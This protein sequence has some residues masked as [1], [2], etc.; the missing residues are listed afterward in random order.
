MEHRRRPGSG[1]ELTLARKLSP[2]PVAG[3]EAPQ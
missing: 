1:N 2:E 3:K